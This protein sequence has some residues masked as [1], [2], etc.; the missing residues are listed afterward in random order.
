MGKDEMHL[1]TLKLELKKKNNV[2]VC[3]CVQ[4]HYIS[5]I[6][7]YS[8][9]LVPIQA[10]PSLLFQL[11][12][13]HVNSQK[14]R[15]ERKRYVSAAGGCRIEAQAAH[16]HRDSQ[17]HCTRIGWMWTCVCA[18]VCVRV[19]VCVYVLAHATFYLCVW[20]SCDKVCIHICV[21]IDRRLAL[22]FSLFGT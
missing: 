13:N 12:C 17:M 6:I 15:R 2:C 3:V 19:C 18:C 7:H 14:N 11:L 20:R 21:S 22:C 8:R 10:F 9:T 1:M 4:R 5:F 16:S